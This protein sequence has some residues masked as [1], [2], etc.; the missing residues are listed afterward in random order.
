MA[1]SRQA[2]TAARQPRIS[3]KATAGGFF[4][5]RGRGPSRG[6]PREGRAR[7]ACRLEEEPGAALGLIDPDFDEAGGCVVA[8]FGRY[9]MCRAHT[10]RERAVVLAQLRKHLFGRDKLLVVI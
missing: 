6:R 1:A 5:G 9:F 4:L 8:G 2:G 3:R 7:S 10:L